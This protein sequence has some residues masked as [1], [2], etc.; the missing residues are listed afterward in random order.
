MWSFGFV[1][2][3]LIIRRRKM[4]K[5]TSLML[6]AVLAA[7]VIFSSC[8]GGSVS[9]AIDKNLAPTKAGEYKWK[10]VIAGG[11][12][13]IDGIVYHPAE[14][15]LVYLRTDMGGAYRWNPKTEEW[16][17]ITD[18]FGR[19][20]ADVPGVLSLALDPND[21][22]KV[23]MMTGKY[24]QDW[25]GK[26]VF[27]SSN[28][29]GITYKKIPLEFKVGGNEDGRG[30]GERLAV[31][32]NKGSILFMGSTKDGL[33][34]SSDS[35]D[36]WTRV[37]SFTPVNINF[38]FFDKSSGSKGA[39][40][41]RIFVSAAENGKSFYVSNDAGAT[42]KLVPGAPLRLMALRADME[43]DN[44]YITFSDFPG[45]NGATWGLGFKYN[46][47]S[48]VWTDL[49]LPEGQGGFS[50]VS[51][52]AQNPKHILISTLDN[53]GGPDDIYRT[54]NGGKTWTKKIKG[55]KWDYSY[56]AYVSHDNTPHWIAVVAIDPFDSNKAMWVTGYGLWATKNLSA[57]PCTWYFNDKNL[58]QTVP[59]QIISPMSGEAHLVSALGDQDGFRYVDNMDVSPPDKHKPPRWTTLSVAYASLDPMKM[60]KTINKP[61]YGAMS[62]DNG[63]NW[64]DF[65]VKPADAKSGGGTRSIALS[66]DG[67]S[68]VWLPEKAVLVWSK[69]NGNTWNKC[70]GG[71]PAV[72]PIAD[73]V[74]PSKF[75]AYDSNS[76]SMWVSDNGGESFSRRG[77]EFQFVS[78]WTVDDCMAA[79]VPGFENHVWVTADTKGLFRTENSG[80]SVI[81][82]ETVEEAYRMGFGMAAPGNTYPAVFI[83]GKVAGVAG[84]FRS[85]DAGATWVRIN[86]DEHQ[87]GWIHCIIGDPRIYGRCYVS[88]EGRGVLYGEMK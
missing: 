22:N 41:R 70:G 80:D 52:D 35:G 74:H 11:G 72:R 38:V 46:V 7:S 42:W 31:D 59:L 69:D 15:G 39:A 51:V 88:P 84:F 14:K 78:K 85:D 57:N 34:K 53:W 61:P 6:V 44:M 26:G 36:S 27:I 29:R 23:Y 63:I 33:W 50:G 24:T 49:K 32:P 16:V 55:A 76:G 3:K 71:V 37:V 77:G 30:A 58:E 68:I 9:V 66:G 81:K 86:D 75:Y 21:T 56:A 64:L 13:F 25:A 47:T 87:Y 83:V 79:V 20:D 65:K 19:N 60:V 1:V 5:E 17:N 8:G 45:P 67:K 10:S 43:A 48:G 73:T 40:S 82:I 18:M 4:K 54:T 28:D 2:I 12:G 62:V